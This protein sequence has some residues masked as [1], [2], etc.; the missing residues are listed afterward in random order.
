MIDTIMSSLKLV[1]SLGTIAEHN[2][3]TMS[4]FLEQ[5][6]TVIDGNISSFWSWESPPPPLKDLWPEVA[7]DL[8]EVSSYFTRTYAETKEWDKELRDMM[9]MVFS[10]VSIDEAYRSREQAASLKRLSWIT[11]SYTISII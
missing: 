1:H 9:Q 5:D 3:I 6:T 2:I 10:V 4:K 11:V 7:H 8:Q